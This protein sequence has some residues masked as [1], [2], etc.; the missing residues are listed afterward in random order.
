MDWP[1]YD[2]VDINRSCEMCPRF[3]DYA[4]QDFQRAVR[5]VGDS[6]EL[7]QMVENSMADGDE[8]DFYFE[9]CSWQDDTFISDLKES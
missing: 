7:V 8:R 4:Q 9:R 3:E 2:N 1:F 5:D 6:L